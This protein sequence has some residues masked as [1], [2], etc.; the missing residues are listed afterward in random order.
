MVYVWQV[1]AW[2]AS[3]LPAKDNFFC[4]TRFTAVA[5]D[6]DSEDVDAWGG[7]FGVDGDGGLE[8]AVGGLDV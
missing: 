5:G 3:L 6:V 8:G 4:D 7:E 1:Y 2:G